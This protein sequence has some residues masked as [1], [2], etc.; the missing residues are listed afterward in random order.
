MLEKLKELNRNK[1]TEITAKVLI[2]FVIFHLLSV[3][4]VYYKTK[5]NLTNPLI[6]KYLLYGIF[7]PYVPKGFILTI[8]LLIATIL[9]FVKQNLITILICV[10]VIIAYHVTSFEANFQ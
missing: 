6:P 9:K 1:S 5:L 7:E 8:G 10:I 3:F 2:V 4:C